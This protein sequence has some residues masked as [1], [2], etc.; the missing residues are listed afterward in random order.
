MTW[1]AGEQGRRFSPDDVAF[2]EDLAQR[3]AVAIDNAQLHTELREMAMSLQRAVLP[4][5]LP[6]LEGWELAAHYS[7]AG[8][9]EAG[10][11][12]YDVIPLEQGR[13]AW[14][15]GDVMGRGVHAAAAMA[16]MRSAIRALVAVD[17]DPSAVLAGLDTFFE[18]YD[19]NQLVTLLYAVVDPAA[20]EVVIANAGH[21]SPVVLRADGQVEALALPEALLL[22]A[23]G[24]LR[25]AT[26]FPFGPGDALLVFTDGLVERRHEDIDAGQRRLLRECHRLLTG[27]LTDALVD[28]VQAVCDPVR[29]D[30]VAVL[31]LRRATYPADS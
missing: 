27:A 4:A 26:A 24:T 28:L 21:L 5:A 18:R 8:Q 25:A 19:L 1:A 11:D 20:D 15:I 6:R 16:Q 12:F 30:D 9:L 3:A 10:G 17:P 23:G 22:G 2:G 31:V 29:D 14:F 7:P 13:L